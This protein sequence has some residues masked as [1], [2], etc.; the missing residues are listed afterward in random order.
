MGEPG[1]REVLAASASD[2]SKVE[3]RLS[4]ATDSL[5]VAEGRAGGARGGP[6][7]RRNGRGVTR[8]KRPGDGYVPG[9]ARRMPPGGSA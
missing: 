6:A 2:G 8:V 5:P 4:A 3:P 1:V 9:G 7:A